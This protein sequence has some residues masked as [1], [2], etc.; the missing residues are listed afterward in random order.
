MWPPSCAGPVS[1]RFP[2]QFVWDDAAIFEWR[3]GGPDIWS[4]S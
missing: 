1:P 3:D 4:M 2:P